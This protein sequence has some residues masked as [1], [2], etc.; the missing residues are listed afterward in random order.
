MIRTSRAATRAAG[1]LAGLMVASLLLAGCGSDD[2]P[3]DSPG[4]DSAAPTRSDP[5]SGPTGDGRDRDADESWFGVVDDL[6][7]ALTRPADDHRDRDRHRHD[8]KDRR[9]HHEHRDRAPKH[10]PWIQS[11]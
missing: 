9:R 3:A 4:D 5:A 8:S 11:G 7:R 2:R 6:R 10:R 1:T